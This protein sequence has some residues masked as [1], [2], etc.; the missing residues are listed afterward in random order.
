MA[1]SLVAGTGVTVSGSVSG[2]YVIY[3]RPKTQG[4]GGVQ[5]DSSGVNFMLTV[6]GGAASGTS[7]IAAS[8]KDTL[9]ST[10][11]HQMMENS[12]GTL[13]AWSRNV[14]NPG[15][16]TTAYYGVS[17]AFPKNADVCAIAVTS[18]ATN[19]TITVSAKE[20]VTGL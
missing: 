11:Y 3:K 6:A 10:E 20:D 14:P 7:A 18:G 15:N 19:L 1:M 16:N 17:I 13:A 2:S 12:S 9:V 8:W 5:K 4:T